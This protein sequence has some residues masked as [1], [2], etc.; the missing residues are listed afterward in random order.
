MSENDY[1]S[2]F[3]GLE[4]LFCAKTGVVW[5]QSKRYA[6][7]QT[8]QAFVPI[9]KTPNTGMT[10]NPASHR[11]AVQTRAVIMQNY[12]QGFLFWS[13]APLIT[14][15]NITLRLKDVFRFSTKPINEEAWLCF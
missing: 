1:N 14:G 15:D 8:S 13:R 2:H 3:L 9:M 6:N 7:K 5:K 12:A 4:A 11:E 10:L